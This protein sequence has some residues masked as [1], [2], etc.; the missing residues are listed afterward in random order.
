MTTTTRR[1]LLA[2]APAALLAPTLA[3][4]ALAAADTTSPE[5]GIDYVAL[6]ARVA[7]AAEIYVVD[8]A[9]F[10]AMSDSEIDEADASLAW[11]NR[12][13]PELSLDWIVLGD[14]RGLVASSRDLAALTGGA[15]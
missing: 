11:L 13:L 4:A 9:P 15:V 8:P 7:W 12:N 1:A 6:R 5:S 3:P 10:L 2:A 14:V